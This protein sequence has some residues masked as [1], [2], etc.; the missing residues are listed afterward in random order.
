MHGGV[1]YSPYTYIE[2]RLNIIQD[3]VICAYLCTNS[4]P[5]NLGVFCVF[6]NVLGVKRM[7]RHKCSDDYYHN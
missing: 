1:K 3:F 6:F 7:G 5:K 2:Q 4:C